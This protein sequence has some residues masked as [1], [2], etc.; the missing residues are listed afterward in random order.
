MVTVSYKGGKLRF[1]K[2]GFLE[3]VFGVGLENG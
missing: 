2:E 3:E 1:L